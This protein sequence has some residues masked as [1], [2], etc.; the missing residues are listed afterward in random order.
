MSADDTLPW[1]TSRCNRLLR[2]LSSK[3][4][5]LRKEQERERPRTATGEARNASSAFAIKGS[6]HKTTNF[7]RPAH[8]RRGFEKASDPDWRPGAKPGAVRKTTYGGRG[9]GRAAG[10]QRAN[11]DVTNASRPGEIA[12]TPLVS[13][14]GTQLHSSPCVPISPLRKYAKN[15]GPLLVT[16]NAPVTH[17]AGDVHKLVQGLSEA[18]ANLL[19]ATTTGNEKRWKGTRSLMGVCLRKLPVYIELE[20]YFA[21]LDRLEEDGEDEDRDVANDVY[22]H[23]EAQFEQEHGQGWRPF[24]QVVRAHGTAL[25]CGAITDQVLGLVNAL[26]LVTHCLNASA[27]DEAERLLLAYAPL[28][29]P[30]C[31]PLGTGANL[32]DPM[33]PYLYSVKSFVDQTGRHRLL[34][35]ILEHMVALELL[36]LEWLATDAMRPIWDRFVRTISENDHRT[37][38]SASRFFET[39]TLASMGLPD[40]RLLD[41]EVTGSVSRRLQPSARATLRQA[42]DTTFSSLLTVMCSIAMVN[43]SRDDAAGQDIARRITRIINAVAI[44]ISSR[45]DLQD[46]LKLLDP[47]PEDLQTMAQRG[48]WVNFASCLVHLEDFH[49]DAGLISFPTTA[50]IS[51]MNWIA[52]QYLLVAKNPSKINLA[53]ILATIPSFI[54]SIARGTGRIWKDDGFNQLQRLVTALMAT[55]DCRLP[56]KLWTMKRLALE[57]ALEFAHS[58]GDAEH[59]AF[60]C[61]IEKK[62]QTKG[63]LVIIN[64]PQKNDS[65]TTSGGFR[66]E[67]GIGEWVT[68]TPFVQQ[69]VRRQAQKPVRAL[70]LLP[71]PVQ[72]EDER[73]DVSEVEDGLPDTV[74]DTPNWATT[75]VYDD[76]AEPESSPIKKAPRPCTSSLGKRTRPASPMIVIPAKRMHMTPPDSPAIKYYPNLPEDKPDAPR[77]SRRPRHKLHAPTS[78]L[79]T[80]RSRNS[81]ESGLRSLKPTTYAE[82]AHHD[83]EPK[84]SSPSQDD[85]DTSSVSPQSIRRTRSSS[86]HGTTRNIRSLRSRNYLESAT[87]NDDVSERDELSKTPAARPALRKRP[88]RMSHAAVLHKR[89][90]RGYHA[91][92]AA[93]AGLVPLHSDDGSEDELSFH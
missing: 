14:M 29:E 19:Q 91:N 1:T 59:M 23:L 65:P 66:W 3:L 44:T 16:M 63:R 85:A 46:E 47:P 41:D 71:T 25:I 89:Q 15:R 86:S 42:L 72:S 20:D 92:Y 4:A 54:S 32:F 34:Y 31:M 55:F 61:D 21:K 6:P 7:T 8:K 40:E 39:V 49:N 80:Q 22:E 56:H 69:N 82:V 88:S 5:K 73:L 74:P 79:R 67:E 60:A 26:V 10:L 81:L 75:V 52:V 93:A 9:R 24:K 83:S 17:M 28:M 35:E 27:W 36:P 57:S 38:A 33:R 62:M 50:S 53:S 48:L 90:N 68:C 11:S 84:T 45:H 37:L 12:F 64:S 2:P 51:Q 18:F 78:R 43:S 30:V 70:Q 76:D 58:T 87:D 13:R 77:R